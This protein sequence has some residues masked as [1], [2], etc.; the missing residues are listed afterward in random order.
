MKKKIQNEE[1]K[2]DTNTLINLEHYTPTSSSKS[3][4]YRK[5]VYLQGVFK[6]ITKRSEEVKNL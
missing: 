2:L 4:D 6:M 5:I 1:T 3:D